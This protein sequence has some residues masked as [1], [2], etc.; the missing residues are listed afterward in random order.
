MSWIKKPGSNE[1]RG[2]KRGTFRQDVDESVELQV[3]GIDTAIKARVVDI[4]TEGCR[5]RSLVLIDRGRAVTFEWR[6]LTGAVLLLKGTVV[7]RRS[8]TA[9]P[10]FEYGLR[11]QNLPAVQLEAIARDVTEMQRRTAV[12]RAEQKNAPAETA[13]PEDRRRTAF[14]ASVTF[15]VRYRR[16]GRATAL[17][18]K[19]TDLSAGGLCLISEMP[20]ARGQLVSLTF[21]LPDDVLN[22]YDPAD[23]QKRK[24][25]EETTLRAR[26]VRR[27]PGT[28]GSHGIEFLELDPHTREDL[29]RFIHAVQLKRLRR[30]SG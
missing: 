24:P 21:R 29:A 1:S 25:F 10:G 8:S 3:A 17:D 20:L 13:S 30:N 2:N 4:S 11:F 27:L 9:P 18:A 5:F 16:E 12:V 7:S 28:A 26:V 15:P 22:V 6:R 19:A 23:V 14:R